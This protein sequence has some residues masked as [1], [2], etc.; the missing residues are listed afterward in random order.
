[1]LLLR[2]STTLL[3]IT[4]LQTFVSYS[5][6][7]LLVT[8]SSKIST[9]NSPSSLYLSSYE[10]MRDQARLRKGQQININLPSPS[11]LTVLRA[12]HF[13]MSEDRLMQS[14][15][16]YR[17]KSIAKKQVRQPT[18]ETMTGIWG[19]CIISSQKVWSDESS[20]ISP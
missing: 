1:M 4:I 10:A 19:W 17:A 14:R 7:K 2:F 13:L 8:S 12:N 18:T 9:C 6:F 11:Q 15:Q 16:K 20:V 5:S 3:I